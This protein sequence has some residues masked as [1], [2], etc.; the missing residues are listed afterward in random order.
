MLRKSPKTAGG[1]ILLDGSGPFHPLIRTGLEDNL[2]PGG[3]PENAR[4]CLAGAARGGD[5]ERALVSA[6]TDDDSRRSQGLDALPGKPIFSQKSSKSAARSKSPAAAIGGTFGSSSNPSHATS[7]A[8]E[9]SSS[10]PESSR[11][12]K[13][14]P[15]AIATPAGGRKGGIGR[16]RKRRRDLPRREPGLS[17]R[18]RLSHAVVASDAPTPE[19]KAAEQRALVESFETLKDEAANAR[20]EQ[21]LQEDA[22]AHRAIAGGG[23]EAGD[24]ATQR[25]CRPVRKQVV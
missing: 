21:C 12:S 19:E 15:E 18:S 13:R 4:A 25:R 23:G 11:G 2:N 5:S 22:A 20:L 3:E 14:L 9:T 17:R 8:T 10:A 7:S 24:R 16:R 6:K 1:E